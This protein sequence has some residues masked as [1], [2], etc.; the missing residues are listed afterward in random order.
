[1]LNN[2][3]T[4][5]GGPAAC[6]WNFNNCGANDEPFSLHTGGVQALF[7]DGRVKF[8]SE[9]LNIQIVRMLAN[10]KDGGVPGDY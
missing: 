8:L 4:P 1:M 2:W 10:R 3:K 5:V 9:S 7:G 6:P